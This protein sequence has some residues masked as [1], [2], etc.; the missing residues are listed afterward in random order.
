MAL[1]ETTHL[2]LERDGSVLHATLDRPEA[3]NALNEALVGDISHTFDAIRDDREIRTIVLRGAGEHFCAGADLKEVLQSSQSG[4]PD[5][6]RQAIM[7][8][9]RGFGT[10]LRTIDSAPQAVVV[11]VEGAALGGGFGLVCVSDVAIIARDAKMGMP[12]TRRGL[13]PAQIAPFVVE[14]IG[15]TQ[16]R[17][18]GVCGAMFDGAEAVELGVGHYLADDSQACDA[19]LD[20]VLEQIG[21]CA[22]GANAATKAIIRKVGQVDMDRILDDAAA[23]FVDCL[24]GEEGR[25]GTQAFV[26]KRKPAWVGNL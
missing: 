23:S 8:Y 3:R 10:L 12:E 6:R 21:Q 18:I 13:P 7:D 20:K 17:R 1:P 11:V 14:R 16:T 19:R 4:T 15:L 24:M 26:E 9:S 2:T 5:E 25:E 22:P